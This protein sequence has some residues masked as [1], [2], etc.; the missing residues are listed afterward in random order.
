MRV[1]GHATDVPFLNVSPGSSL[2]AYTLKPLSMS[3]YGNFSAN[4]SNE[5]HSEEVHNYHGAPPTFDTRV[6]VSFQGHHDSA[7]PAAKPLVFQLRAA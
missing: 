2:P 7:I 1:G 3:T 6:S 4:S 5:N